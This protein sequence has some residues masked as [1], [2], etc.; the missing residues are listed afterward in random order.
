VPQ[1]CVHCR[2]NQTKE[3][4]K[5]FKDGSTCSIPYSDGVWHADDFRRAKAGERIV[6]NDRF[7][8]R[9]GVRPDDKPQETVPWKKK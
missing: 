5:L 7:Q 6:L 8:L 3:V 4:C 1:D 9:F 2:H